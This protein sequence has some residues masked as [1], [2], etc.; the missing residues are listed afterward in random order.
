MV[1]SVAAMSKAEKDL[2]VAIRGGVVFVH[3]TTE[4]HGNSQ[5]SLYI[6]AKFWHLPASIQS[7][8]SAAVRIHS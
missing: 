7:S 2:L 1:M 8:K 3:L 6:L 4:S 5:R